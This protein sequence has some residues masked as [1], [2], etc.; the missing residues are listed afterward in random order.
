MNNMRGDYQR[1]LRASEIERIKAMLQRA[2]ERRESYTPGSLRARIDG[3]NSLT[4]TA[5]KPYKFTIPDNAR[6]IDL[7]GQDA[8]G[9]L[10]LAAFEIPDL[11]TLEGTVEMEIVHGGSHRYTCVVSSIQKYRQAIQGQV[12]IT[13]EN[14]S[15]KTESK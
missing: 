1:D 6:C 14:T 10:L 4:F 2:E 7:F 3:L 13:Y 5:D 11:T 9:R 15:A 8:E 12:T